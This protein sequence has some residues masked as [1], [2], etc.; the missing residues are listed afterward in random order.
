M[1]LNTRL[2][3][4][5]MVMEEAAVMPKLRLADPEAEIAEKLAEPELTVIPGVEQLS[6]ALP[7]G[8][9]ARPELLSGMTKVTVS[10][11]SRRPLLLPEGSWMVILPK[12]SAG[13]LMVRLKLYTQGV[14]PLMVEVMV[15]CATVP[16][17]M[18]LAI[19][20]L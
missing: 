7:E 16:L 4:V 14:W 13:A 1:A 5:P 20:K 17:A 3:T 19:V 6:V 18:L 8:E 10:P 15:N 12:A 9:E 11:G 2:A